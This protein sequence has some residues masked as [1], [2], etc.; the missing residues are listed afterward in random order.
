[1]P[2]LYVT[3][4]V[5]GSG[6]S[7]WISQKSWDM[8]STVIV[9]TDKFVEQHAD[10]VGKNYSDVFIDYMPTAV[11]MMNSEV[12]AARQAMK[13]VVWDQTSTTRR[14][15]SKKINMFKNHGYKIVAVVFP[16]PNPLELLKRLNSRPNKQ[17]PPAVMSQMISSFS[18]PTRSE[19][20]DEIIMMISP[21][22]VT[23]T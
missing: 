8:S 16:T 23:V 6:K 18:V 2:T 10:E 7:T 9:C 12:L 19:G 5:P 17:I 4:G 1:M 13:N 15:R 11:K 21:D 20:F 14:S 3:V 22:E